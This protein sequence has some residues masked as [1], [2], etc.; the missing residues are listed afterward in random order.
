MDRRSGCGSDLRT[1]CGGR[2]RVVMA[3]DSYAAVSGMQTPGHL[4]RHDPRRARTGDH[5]P[6][7]EL[8]PRGLESTH[9]HGQR[10]E[11]VECGRWPSACRDADPVQVHLGTTA[12]AAAHVRQGSGS[13][14]ISLRMMAPSIR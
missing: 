14:S 2:V 8:D 9:S 13:I 12:L 7:V 5:G 1:P 4:R 10:H 3:R 11:S 6:H